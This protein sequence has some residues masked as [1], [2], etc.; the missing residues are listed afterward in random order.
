MG[1]L[2][3]RDSS[4]SPTTSEKPSISAKTSISSRSDD[5][6]SSTPPSVD[7]YVSQF[8]FP[9]QLY[10]TI[11]C[12]ELAK[13]P[14]PTVSEKYAPFLTG[15]LP[16]FFFGQSAEQLINH[17]ENSRD[18]RFQLY[19]EDP[20]SA[21]MSRTYNGSLLAMNGNL[22]TQTP[23]NQAFQI[24][25]KHYVE[26]CAG[27]ENTTNCT[28]TLRAWI[29]VP[30][31]GH[32]VTFSTPMKNKPEEICGINILTKF[33]KS[34]APGAISAA[35]ECIKDWEDFNF[36]FRETN[37]ELTTSFL[38]WDDLW[39]GGPSIS[40]L[41]ILNYCAYFVI[42][43]VILSTL[44][45]FCGICCCSS[46]WTLGICGTSISILNCCCNSE[47]LKRRKLKKRIA[48]VEFGN[49]SEIEEEEVSDPSH[50]ENEDDISEED[51]VSEASLLKNQEKK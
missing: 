49:E 41:D 10:R 5:T 38:F 36:N 32:G 30:N 6:D 37:S 16:P 25:G 45:G 17:C 29:S 50:D 23:F 51:E 47:K 43:L 7:Q 2:N 9:W 39:E 46:C 18:P 1:R 31:G 19:S 22:D 15:K 8:S 14:Y 24:F 44:I 20:M 12:S 35:S 48:E 13:K 27:S 40:I 11:V 3:P 33:I 21:E 26:K 28:E 42:L 34:G 4:I